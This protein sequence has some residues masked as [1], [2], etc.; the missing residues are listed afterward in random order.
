MPHARRIYRWLLVFVLVGP[1][2]WI[3]VTLVIGALHPSAAHAQSA[4]IDFRTFLTGGHEYAHRH[5]PYPPPGVLDRY[6]VINQER[7]VYPPHM[8]AFF[9]IFAPLPYTV[10]ATIWVLILLAAVPASLFLLGVRDWRC[11]CVALDWPPVLTATTAG[12]IT[13]LLLLGIAVAWRLRDRAFRCGAAIAAV[14]LAKI[15]LWPLLLWLIVTGRR[16]ALAFAAIVGA[17]AVTAAWA[18]IGFRGAVDYPAVLARLGKIEGPHGYQSAWLLGDVA[19]RAL[20][21]AAVLLAGI[22][23]RSGR[24]ADDERLL[25]VVALLIGL[26]TSP[27]IWLHY[28]VLLLVAVALL[29][30]AVSFAWLFP[31]ALFA[32]IG[33]NAVTRVSIATA[34]VTAIAV[35]G[36]L[37]RSRTLPSPK[38]SAA[39]ASAS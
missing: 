21:A 27:I 35:S 19:P 29:E 11:Y 10:A 20:I 30:P 34:V 38:L 8:A 17:A 37:A 16:R 1:T 31:F 26:A 36:F 12:A 39:A 7:F 33:G 9:A 4:L 14:A 23:L 13:P 22:Y 15:F 6:S 25:L 18:W 2:C 28:F 5:S 3:V 32:T 24:R